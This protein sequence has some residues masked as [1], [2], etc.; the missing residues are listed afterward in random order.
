MPNL[1]LPAAQ[2]WKRLGGPQGGF[3]QMVWSRLFEDKWL[4]RYWD[5]DHGWGEGKQLAA[6]DDVAALDWIRTRGYLIMQDY[7]T[8]WY[9]CPPG[10][11]VWQ[12]AQDA[13]SPSA[14][15]VA[16][17]AWEAAHQDA[18]EAEAAP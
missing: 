9:W 12:D 11:D 14:L 10:A 18:V 16:I 7:D 8:R 1:D 6:P 3:P 13:P 5:R 15:V 4:L 17:A 2:A